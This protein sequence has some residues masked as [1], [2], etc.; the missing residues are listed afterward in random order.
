MVHHGHARACN[1]NVTC[2]DVNVRKIT[3][4]AIEFNVHICSQ[5]PADRYRS[6]LGLAAATRRKRYDQSNSRGLPLALV[7]FPEGELVPP[8]APAPTPAPAPV[9]GEG[10]AALPVPFARCQAGLK[11]ALSPW[12]GRSLRNCPVLALNPWSPRFT[13]CEYV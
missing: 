12:L 7:R 11:L 6:N 9:A 4:F 1:C 2:V 5:L 10:K 13:S 8:P 3:W